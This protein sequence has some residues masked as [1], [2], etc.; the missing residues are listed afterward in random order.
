MA[1]FPILAIAGLAV[2]M[3]FSHIAYRFYL[4][5]VLGLSAAAT[6][7]RLSDIFEQLGHP[8]ARRGSFPQRPACVF[9]E[10][11]NLGPPRSVDDGCVPGRGEPAKRPGT[12]G[13]TRLFAVVR[14]LHY[15]I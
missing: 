8:S 7:F 12:R 4:P 6:E 14:L 3:F 9:W 10:C 5:T 2:N 13:D 1:L 15:K 11:A